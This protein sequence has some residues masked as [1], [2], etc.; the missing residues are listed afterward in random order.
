MII[1]LIE[2]GN[3]DAAR[4][5]TGEPQQTA[6]CSSGPISGDATAIVRDRCVEMRRAIRTM[7]KLA[8]ETAFDLWSGYTRSTYLEKFEVTYLDQLETLKVLN[9]VESKAD[10]RFLTRKAEVALLT[11]FKA[12][13]RDIVDSVVPDM[14]EVDFRA[15]LNQIKDHAVTA[16]ESIGSIEHTAANS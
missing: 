15:M 8:S 12:V 14:T 9:H 3:S 7:L 2:T 11:F 13:Q 16:S 1:S 5:T 4:R 10:L 6:A